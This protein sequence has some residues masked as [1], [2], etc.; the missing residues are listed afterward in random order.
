MKEALKHDWA[1]LK[2]KFLLSKDHDFNLIKDDVVTLAQLGFDSAL[3]VYCIARTIE[4][5]EIVEQILSSYPEM[6][7][8]DIGLAQMF[9][10]YPMDYLKKARLRLEKKHQREIVATPNQ[11]LEYDSKGFL[12]RVLSEREFV[13]DFPTGVLIRFF[14]NI[15]RNPRGVSDGAVVMAYVGLLSRKIEPTQNAYMAMLGVANQPYSNYF[16]EQIEA[17]KEYY[18]IDEDEQ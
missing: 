2:A 10:K 15:T 16:Y 12:S 8:V 4:D 11:A 6:D 3:A 14:D 7:A 17:T 18:M 13:E 9:H 5:D 1:I